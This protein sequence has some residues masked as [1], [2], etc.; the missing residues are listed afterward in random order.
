MYGNPESAKRWD[1]LLRQAPL[2]FR[3]MYVK[4]DDTPDSGLALMVYAAFYPQAS[5]APTAE[6]CAQ[7]AFWLRQQLILSDLEEQSRLL[8]F[9]TKRQIRFGRLWRFP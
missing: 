9:S 8:G 6:Q 2:D 3:L 5:E 1:S 4:A 7:A